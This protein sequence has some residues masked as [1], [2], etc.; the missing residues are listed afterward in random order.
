MNPAGSLG[1]ALAAT[2][3]ADLRI[4]VVAGPA[5]GAFA[6]QLVRGESS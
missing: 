6:C 2:G 4:Y 1:P 5:A 3:P